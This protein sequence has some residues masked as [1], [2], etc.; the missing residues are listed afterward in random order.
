[1]QLYDRS[2][3][4]IGLKDSY[5]RKV[6]YR[7]SD[8]VTG[9][10]GLPW[11]ASRLQPEW[12]S[13]LSNSRTF[14]LSWCARWL[15]IASTERLIPKQRITAID[16]LSCQESHLTSPSLGQRSVSIYSTFV[17]ILYCTVTKVKKENVSGKHF[18]N[19]VGLFHRTHSAL[20]SDCDRI[21][22]CSWEQL[23]GLVLLRT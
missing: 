1:M 18:F 4:A 12:L 15:G 10:T 19:I 17:F 11:E 9:I 13:K 6:N 22:I 5:L 14:V 21:D 2:L 8:H 20:F 16:T 23:W 7:G 3:W